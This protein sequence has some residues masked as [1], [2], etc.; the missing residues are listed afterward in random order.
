M[1]RSIKHVTSSG[2]IAALYVVFTI[3]S[4]SLGLSSGAIQFRLSE[5]LC[6]VAL[7]T[8]A[9]IPGL[10]I[11]CILAN[12]LTGCMLLDVVFGSVATWLGVTFAYY[13][14]KQRYV[15]L[16]GPVISNML[17]VPLILIHVYGINSSY[18]YLMLTVGIGEF[19]CAYVAGQVL[20]AAIA[21][22]NIEA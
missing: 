16:L 15:A 14:R 6:A 9:A 3:I 21:Q 11:G 8:P 13:M 20:Y 10:T 22:R 17:I 12:L 19:A 5:C 4:A 18:L 2:L 7:I 1:S